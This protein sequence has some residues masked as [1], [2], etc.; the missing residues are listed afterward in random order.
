MEY[1][2]NRPAKFEQV[3][4]ET[5]VG[6]MGCW[7]QALVDSLGPSTYLGSI[8]TRHDIL[9][10]P[11]PIISRVICVGFSGYITNCQP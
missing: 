9:L 3:S 2:D 5:R 6:K 10:N 1:R 11:N 4:T 7:V 8:Q